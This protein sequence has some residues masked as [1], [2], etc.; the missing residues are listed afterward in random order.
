MRSAPHGDDSR[1]DARATT[2]DVAQAEDFLFHLHRGS[3][4][5]LKN[6]VL[7]AKE[8]LER[9][10]QHQPQDAKSQDLLAGVYF[11]LGVYPRAIE[12]WSGLVSAYPADPTLRVNLALAYFKTG[13]ADDA[14]EHVHGVLRIQP[15]HERAWGYLGLINWRRGKIV[16]ARDAFLRGGQASMARRMEELLEEDAADD[17]ARKAEEHRIEAEHVARAIEDYPAHRSLPPPRDPRI[18]VAHAGETEAPAPAAPAIAAEAHAPKPP[19]IGELVAANLPGVA[20]DPV[21]QFVTSGQLYVRVVDG[22]CVRSD[23]IEGVVAS[24]VGLPVPRRVG[25]QD[26]GTLLGGEHP[27]QRY[28]GL[29]ELRLEPPAG[30][31]LHPLALEAA[32]LFVLESH[33][34]GFSSTVEIECNQVPV[35]DVDVGVVRLLGSGT[36]VVWAKGALSPISIARGRDARVRTA[37]LIGWTGAVF[38]SPATGVSALSLVL[39]GDGAVLLA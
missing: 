20:G 2:A 35:G 28:S 6:R 24:A 7:E 19:S 16:E 33:L 23:L 26:S 12:I 34:V 9:A 8:E 29:V 18:A 5:L 32:P 15:D 11:R 1:R 37:S 38:V 4:M 25:G 22:F 3:E 31:T 36:V 39:R 27:M 21:V 30:A 17:A 14:L 10:L 13:Q